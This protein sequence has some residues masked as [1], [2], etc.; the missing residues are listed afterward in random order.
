M[1][2]FMQAFR[3][4]QH[5][6]G[7]VMF[8]AAV[9]YTVAAL[10]SVIVMLTG[11]DDP[12]QALTT[13][14]ITLG[15]ANGISYF[16]HLL[17]I[18]ASFRLAGVGV[19]SA[20]LST[21]VIIPVL[22]AHLLWDDKAN[23]WQWAALGLLPIGMLLM[24]PRSANGIHLTWRA[25][26]LLVLLFIGGGVIQTIHKAIDVQSADAGAS[27]AAVRHVYIA[28]LF[29]TTALCTIAY[30]VATR[31]KADVAGTALGAII[32]AI[33]ATLTALIL[34]ALSVMSAAVYF[35]VSTAVVVALNVI[36]SWLFWHERITRRQAVGLIVAV[37][38]VVLAN[39]GGENT[40]DPNEAAT[41][42]S[43][44]APDPSLHDDTAD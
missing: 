14:V 20:I 19:T 29:V 36:I 34:L 1:V 5:R 15:L 4:A 16:L 17:I 6:S 11:S 31:V 37:I 30:A 44:P 2:G 32:G 26:V 28:V 24:R 35:P 39:F 21:A 25:D 10:I 41:G 9:N 3:Y 18:L 22:T 12:T 13:P 23:A 43:T 8:V 27:H 42:D 33:N 7:S 40:D 38:I